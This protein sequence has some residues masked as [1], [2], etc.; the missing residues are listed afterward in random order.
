MILEEYLLK[1]Y[2]K[3]SL[4]PYLCSIRKYFN[5]IQDKAETAQ[6]KDILEYIVHLRKNENLQ[7]KTIKHYLLNVKIYY[8][9]LI[10]I[11]KRN[12]HP[13][14]ELYLKDKINKQ[15]K[16]DILYSAETLEKYLESHKNDAK[17]VRRRN[18]VITSLLICKF[19]L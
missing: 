2:K 1:K 13:C 17:L 12:D 19:K 8:Y 11:G 5:F 10:E 4:N 14:S 15:I 9:Y 6:Y 3:S 7:P 18:E 16:V